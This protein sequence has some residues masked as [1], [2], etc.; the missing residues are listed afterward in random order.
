[1]S[2][3]CPNWLIGAFDNP[4]RRLI[5]NPDRIV[6]GRVGPGQTAADI[7]CGIGYFTIPLARL[8][9]SQGKVLVGVRSGAGVGPQHLI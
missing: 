4:L 8:V 2:H 1:M 9:G 7:G 6:S 5:Q 3:V